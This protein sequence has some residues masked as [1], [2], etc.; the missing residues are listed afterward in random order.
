MLKL[1]I[2]KLSLIPFQC[3]KNFLTKTT[4]DNIFYQLCILGAFSMLFSL[5]LPHFCFLPHG[6]HAEPRNYPGLRNR[7]GFRVFT[8]DLLLP[9]WSVLGVFISAY[10]LSC[11]FIFEDSFA[12]FGCFLTEY[13]YIFIAS[14]LWYFLAGGCR[15]ETP[16][17]PLCRVDVILPRR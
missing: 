12:P 14:L 13:L 9:K 16:G 15:V 10:Y 17:S 1:L 7:H 11:N 5:P 8:G 3:K 6:L 2:K 4:L